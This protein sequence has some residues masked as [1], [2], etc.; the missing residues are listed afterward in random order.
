MRES[1]ARALLNRMKTIDKLGLVS[2]EDIK[3]EDISR[4]QWPAMR[5]A[6]GNETR[7]VIAN[8]VWNAVINFTLSVSTQMPFQDTRRNEL[9][10]AITLA[11]DSDPALSGTATDA[12]VSEINFDEDSSPYGLITIELVV[13][14]CYARSVA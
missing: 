7:E 8:D 10:D 2:R 5:I 3:L 9:I 6:S 14:Y 13:T 1:I 4:Q 11:I 12:Y